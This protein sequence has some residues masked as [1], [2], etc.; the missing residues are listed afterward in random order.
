L[1]RGDHKELLARDGAYAQM[2]ALQQEEAEHAV[3]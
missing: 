3:A 2:W 1:E